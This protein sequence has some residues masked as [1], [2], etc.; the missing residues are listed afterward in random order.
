MKGRSVACAV[1]AVIFCATACGARLTSAERAA[2]IAA[3]TRNGGTSQAGTVS[4][5]LGA[6]NSNSSGATASGPVSGPT[7][8]VASAS[9]AST[10]PP[11]GNGGATDRGVT[12]NS[13]T[14]AT[15]ADV[16]G[17]QPGIFRAAW[18]AMSALAAYVNSTGG[19]YGRQIKPLLLDSRADSVANRAAVQQACD[20][21]FA[22]VG[23]MSA[24]D[25]GGASVG[26]KCGIPDLS[27]ITVNAARQTA[28]NVYAASPNR[29]DRINTSW[30]RYIKGKYPEEIKHSAMLWLNAGA[31]A[32]NGAQRLKAMTAMGYNFVYKAEVQVLEGNYSPYVQA[33]KDKGVQLVNMVAD[34]QSVIRVQ[35]SMEQAG[36]FPKVRLWDSVIYSQN[37][38]TT[39]GSAVNGGLVFLN[40]AMFEEV[41]NNPE[42]QLYEQWLQRT[43]PGAVPDYFGMYA[44]SA[45]RLFQKAA[46]AAGPKLTRA[47][48]F[49]QVKQIHNWSDYG[50]HASHDVGNTLE[51]NCTLFAEVRNGHFVRIYPSK[52][53]DCSG[54]LMK[55]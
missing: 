16:T 29:P 2:G 30:M 22:L 50:L 55:T 53:W 14:L 13:I 18:Q 36:W 34:Y 33:M 49:A 47:A 9:A 51:A 43:A 20:Q 19:I 17:V 42:M 44:W 23:S 10:L 7:G 11:G 48:L 24:F 52:S 45:G 46:L 54:S 6:T 27:A 26:Q 41:A 15:A 3:L 40:T 28:T 32:Q 25:D 31:T 12:G 1:L 37:Y 4:S 8:P 5:G 39:G 38:L 35:K 21:A